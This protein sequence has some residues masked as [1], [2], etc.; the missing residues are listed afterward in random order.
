MNRKEKQVFN[1]S[2]TNC[3]SIQPSHEALASHLASD[4]YMLVLHLD[5]PKVPTLPA[6]PLQF[7][8][9]LKASVPQWLA[10]DVMV[11]FPAVIGPDIDLA[12]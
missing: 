11:R 5:L 7:S 9:L 6:L 1:G 12:N 2:K 8:G 4:K 3:F 10:P